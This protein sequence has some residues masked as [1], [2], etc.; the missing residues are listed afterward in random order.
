MARTIVGCALLAVL[1]AAFV[2]DACTVS[3]TSGCYITSQCTADYFKTQ[4]ATA[5]N[6]AARNAL[7]SQFTQ[8]TWIGTVPTATPT[9]ATCCD[10]P[11]Y[12]DHGVDPV[13]CASDRA[14]VPLP[15]TVSGVDN[16]GMCVQKEKLC[17]LLD[18]TDCP[19]YPF[20]AWMNNMCDYTNPTAGAGGTATLPPGE[21]VASKCPTLHPVVVVILALMFLTL[22]GAIV[23]VA[24]IVVINQRKADKEEAEREAAALRQ[25]RR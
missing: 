22:V 15:I 20:C 24:V 17:A 13:A 4:I 25:G 8:C 6:S 9:A 2:V 3:S 16:T 10:D 12:K 19:M 23:V 5:P 14:C 1:V 7:Y 11:C 18:A 21:D